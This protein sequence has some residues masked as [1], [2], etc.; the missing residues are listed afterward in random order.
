MSFWDLVQFTV[1]LEHDPYGQQQREI[2]KTIME[3]NAMGLVYK[4]QLH[5]NCRRFWPL[6]H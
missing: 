4:V 2:K 6:S 5:P 3:W 1:N